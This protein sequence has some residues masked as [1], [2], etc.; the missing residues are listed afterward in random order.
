[1]PKGMNRAAILN[2]E[3]AI[4]RRHETFVLRY[5]DW[6]ADGYSATFSQGALTVRKTGIDED[7]VEDMPPVGQPATASM[8]ALFDQ[9]RHEFGESS[10][11]PR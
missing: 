6:S 2:I 7:T 9:V 11:E 4:R 10:K 1:M 8:A 5:L 3:T